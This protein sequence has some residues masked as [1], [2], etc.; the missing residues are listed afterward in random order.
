MTRQKAE[1]DMEFHCI[2]AHLRR[3]PDGDYPHPLFSYLRASV[4]LVISLRDLSQA[5]F[6]G[7]T[8][9]L[10]RSVRHFSMGETSR[11]YMGTLDQAFSA[12]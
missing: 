7:I 9:R 2:C 12:R 10:A 1:R 6:E 8:G 3:R 4:R 5:E 11:N